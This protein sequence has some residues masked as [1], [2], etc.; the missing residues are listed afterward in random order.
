M[1]CDVLISAFSTATSPTGGRK[2]EMVC[3]GFPK[4]WGKQPNWKLTDGTRACL[5]VLARP[6]YSVALENDRLISGCRGPQ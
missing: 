6:A 3:L 1:L 2:Q 5:L 4:L